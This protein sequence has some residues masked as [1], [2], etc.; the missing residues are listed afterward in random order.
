[1]TTVAAPA[2]PHWDLS[3]V[4]PSLD[5]PELAAATRSIVTQLD[6]LEAYLDAHA[7]AQGRPP[8]DPAPA[9]VASVIAGYLERANAL[10]RLFSTVRAYL[11]GH[12][13]T[14][15]FN[16]AAKR[17]FSELQLLGVRLQQQGVRFAGWLGERA[18]DLPA[19]TA[20]HPL[21]QKHAF[22]LQETAEQS[23]YLMSEAEETLAAELGVSGAQAW[24][25]LQGTICSQ[26][27]VPFERAGTT[28]ALP[29]PALQ[30]LY[31]DP[32]P[33]VRRRAYEA[34]LA[35]LASVR[36]PL[37]ACLNGVKGAAVTLAK[38]RGRTDPLHAALDDS[39]IDR[40]T[41]DALLGAMQDSFPAFRRYLKK[42]AERLGR[43]A[44]PWYDLLAP[45][46]TSER[47]FTFPEAEAFI[48]EQFGSFSPRLAEFARRA[49]IGRWIDAEPRSG[50]RGGAFCMGL[51]AVEESRVLM[52]FDGSLDQVFT[53][54][55]ELGHGFHNA[56][57]AG[58]PA[59]LRGL[60]MT[61]A[62][63]ASI[64]CETIVTEAMLAE[65]AGP[66]E[67]LSILETFLMGTTQVVVDIASR[68]RFESEVFARRAQA[69]LSAEDLCA[70]ML[71]AQAETYG[72]GLD[73]SVRHPYMWTW[74]PHYYY[75]GLSF[76]NFPYTFGLLFGTGLYALYQERGPAFIPDYEALL[77]HTGQGKAAE[78]AGR[79]GIDLRGRAFWENSLKVIE[80][81]IDRY[82]EL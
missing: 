49:F 12:V 30:N 75:A 54:A 53:L 10:L 17:Q 26:L 57:L 27:S 24:S 60:P 65:A 22:F 63:T 50:K 44:L 66:A 64:F 61:L 31:H 7:I 77:A 40:A 35:A 47:T 9:A 67:E 46:G 41:L 80:R 1:M 79:F 13:A 69:E 19:L 32:D 20:A 4:Y 74:K 37:A 42:K 51:P 16:P 81:R 56:C 82:C 29:L 38:R 36:E 55:H 23:R 43:P 58:Q 39:R 73:L 33:D 18:A 2:L 45:L 70:L 3:S 11:S 14:D 25:K 34:E 59:L 78:L 15:S 6:A 62:E 21:A 5:S 8:A 76:Y 52:N 71:Q 68:F 48:V 28:Q 72:D